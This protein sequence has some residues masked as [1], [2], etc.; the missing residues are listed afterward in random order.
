MTADS[1]RSRHGRHP[2]ALVGGRTQLFAA[3]AG[4][5]TADEGPTV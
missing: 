1:R 2:S 5:E 4:S 3:L